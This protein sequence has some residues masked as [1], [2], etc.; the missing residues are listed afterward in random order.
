M[1]DTPLDP[2][3]PKPLRL[4][5]DPD[6]IPVRTINQATSL[7]LGSVVAMTLITDRVGFDADGSARPDPVIAARLRFDLEIAKII[8]DQLDVQIGLLSKPEGKAN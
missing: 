7:I 4:P 3:L 8:R 5:T 2:E 6:N 1:P